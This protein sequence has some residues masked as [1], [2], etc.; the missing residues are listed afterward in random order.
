[1]FNADINDGKLETP[2]TKEWINKLWYSHTEEQY[3]AIRFK[4][5]LHIGPWRVL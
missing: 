3:V 5:D 4:L 2:R 1:M